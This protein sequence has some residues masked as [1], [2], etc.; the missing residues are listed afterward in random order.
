MGIGLWEKGW[1]RSWTKT[2]KASKAWHKGVPMAADSVRVFRNLDV[3]QKERQPTWPLKQQAEKRQHRTP[4]HPHRADNNAGAVITIDDGYDPCVILQLLK[5]DLGPFKNLLDLVQHLDHQKESLQ[6]DTP[7]FLLQAPNCGEDHAISLKETLEVREN[8]TTLEVRENKKYGA[9][10]PQTKLDEYSDYRDRLV[11]KVMMQQVAIML[12]VRQERKVWQVKYNGRHASQQR[13]RKL[14]N[15]AKE[16]EQNLQKKN[17]KQEADENLIKEFEDRQKLAATSIITS[18]GRK[19]SPV[20]EREEV[21]DRTKR[22]NRR[23]RQAAASL[24][25]K[26]KAH[27]QQEDAH[28]FLTD[29]VF[30]TFE[31]FQK[32]KSRTQTPPNPMVA[33]TH[34]QQ[35]VPGP[36]QPP[37]AQPNAGVVSIDTNKSGP[38]SLSEHDAATKLVK[39]LLATLEDSR[40][41][42]LKTGGQ[43]G[44]DHETHGRRMK[45]VGYHAQN[46]HSWKGGH[47]T[48]METREGNFKYNG[49]PE[50]HAA[51]KPFLKPVEQTC[52]RFLQ[53][54]IDDDDAPNNRTQHK[55]ELHSAVTV[56]TYLRPPSVPVAQRSSRAMGKW[57]SQAA[58]RPPFWLEHIVWPKK[59]NDLPTP[60]LREAP[61]AVLVH[62]GEDPL[63]FQ[64]SSN[65]GA[66][67]QNQQGLP[68][69]V[70]NW[71]VKADELDHLAGIYKHKNFHHKSRDVRNELA[72][73]GTRYMTSATPEQTCEELKDDRIEVGRTFLSPRDM[74]FLEGIAKAPLLMSDQD[75]DPEDPDHTWLVKQPAWRSEKLNRILKL[76][77]A[78]LDK[79][80]A[81]RACHQRKMATTP[82]PRPRPAGVDSCYLLPEDEEGGDQE[83]NVIVCIS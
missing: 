34:S 31:Q 53:P 48:S 40:T 5:D 70:P 30:P 52:Q 13:E 73:Q 35:P 71:Q 17:K 83:A 42:K 68:S 23:H 4:H 8:K 72:G 67:T 20:R 58:H 81:S 61:A 12:K 59:L 15:R 74:Q 6:S 60:A 62:V 41:I 28:E 56:V 7:M 80:K 44:T 9:T 33:P 25:S 57:G 39:R 43:S 76:C 26:A 63:M 18:G 49:P 14:Q 66:P 2:N 37:P 51:L 82:S 3:L 11:V 46:I 16:H 27:W 24:F 55:S 32:K 47:A 1:T 75:T 50:L 65:T 64:A 69:T 19:R 45:A 78:R 54:Q 21:Q 79:T 22:T 77:Q 29:V 10:V 38:L 36:A